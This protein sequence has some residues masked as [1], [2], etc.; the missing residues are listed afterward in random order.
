MGKVAGQGNVSGATSAQV[1]IPECIPKINVKY[2]VFCVVKC[3]TMITM[4][5]SLILHI[6]SSDN[7]KTRKCTARAV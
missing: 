4:P 6:R 3:C 2:S 7:K 1:L 5:H